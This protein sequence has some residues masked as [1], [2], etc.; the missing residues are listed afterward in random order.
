MFQ[1]FK[2][3]LMNIWEQLKLINFQHLTTINFELKSILEGY[4]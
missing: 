3:R 4:I 1:F 2:K